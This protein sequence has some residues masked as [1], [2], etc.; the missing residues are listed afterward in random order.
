MAKRLGLILL[1]VAPV[2]GQDASTSVRLNTIHVNGHIPP[3]ISQPYN[4]EWKTT[5]TQ[6][7]PDG[8]TVTF[9]SKEQ[10][11][12][13]SEGRTVYI[14]TEVTPRPGIT[15]PSVSYRVTDP[16]AGANIQWYGGRTGVQIWHWPAELSCTEIPTPSS[17]A[18]AHR[19]AHKSSPSPVRKETEDLGTDSILGLQVHGVRTTSY[20]PPGT[21]GNSGPLVITDEV[22][23]LAGNSISSGDLGSDV[24]RT[25]ND[26][27]FGV[28]TK[29]LVS[30]S[31][32][33]P[34][35]SLFRPPAGYAV[36]DQ[37]PQP[38]KCPAGWTP[39]KEQ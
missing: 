8:S 2:L 6:T 15:V 17:A 31:Q 32:T 11:A 23:S 20:I 22:W 25:M 33:E 18:T 21:V 38:T 34:D 1:L 16:A 37:E 35:P 24:R 36:D 10:Q 13:D 19:A 5:K 12:R 7:L 29:E 39:Q 9:E 27:R 28:T 26:P 4:A 30:F 14:T 3:I